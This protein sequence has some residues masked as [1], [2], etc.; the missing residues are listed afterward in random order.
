VS[1]LPDPQPAGQHT[2]EQAAPHTQPGECTP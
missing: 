1:V 2:E